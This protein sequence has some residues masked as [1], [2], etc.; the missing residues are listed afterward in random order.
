MNT[1]APTTD[2]GTSCAINSGNPSYF[3]SL[4]RKLLFCLTCL[5][6]SSSIQAQTSFSTEPPV[7]I[8]EFTKFINAAKK[9]ELTKTMEAF[10]LAWKSNK[11]VPEQQTFIIRIC[12]NMMY[13]QLPRDPYFELLLSNLDLYYKK[14]FSP[15]LLKQWQL[16]SKTLLDKSPKEY[17]AFLETANSLFQDNTFCNIES[18]RWYASNSNFEFGFTNN[19]VSIIYKNL[20]LIC[21]AGIDKIKIFNCSG[22][23]YPDKHLW[24]GTQGRINWARV[25]KPE[26]EVHCEFHRHKIDFATAGFSVD[27]ALLT[28]PKVSSTKI[29]GKLTEKV[30]HASDSGTIKKSGYPQFVSYEPTIEIKGI[31]GDQAIYKGGFTIKGNITNSQN[32]GEGYASITLLFK[33]K[34]TVEIK[35][36]AFRLDSGKV[37]S[38]HASVR[39]KADTG[40]ITHP[41]II[42]HYNITKKKMTLTKGSEGLMRMAFTDTY[43]GVE[44]D[45]DQV[46]WDQGQPNMDFDMLANDKTAYV[47]T[48]SFFKK[49][50]FEKQQGALNHNPL[51]TLFF[52]VKN[53]KDTSG[54]KKGIMRS[55]HINDYASYLGSAKEHLVQQMMNLADDGFI[56]YNKDNDSIYVRDKLYN[57]ISNNKGAKDYD[58][59]RFA[60]VIAAKPNLT[61]NF[62]SHE[63]KME[64]VRRF[65]FSDSQN[66]LAIPT[67]QLLIIKKDKN[68]HFSGMIRA[69]RIDFFSKDFNFN[70]AGFQIDNTTID[71]MV[72][73]YPDMNTNTLRKVESV[74]SNTYGR[75]LIDKSNNKSGLKDYPEYPIF[76]A[77]RGSEINYDRAAT[78]NHAYK[79]DKFKFEVDPF[80]IDSL[81]NFTI[82]GFGF[83]GTLVSDGIFPDIKNVAR[84]QPDYSLGFVDKVN[85]PMYGGKGQGDLTINLSNRGFYGSGNLIYETSVSKS[86]EYL[87]LP[88]ATVGT[89]TSFDLPESAKYP[90]VA[91]NNV[92]TEWYPKQDKMF[93]TKLD[94]NFRMFKTQYDFEGKLT[95]TPQ[96][97]RGDG[98][99]MWPEAIF[100]SNEMV[101]GRNKSKADVSSIR[102]YAVDPSKFAFESN[103]VKGDV[104]FDKREGKFLTNVVGSMTDFPFN[105][106]SSNMNDYKWDMNKKTM[107]VK[108]GAAM[109]GMK[110]FFVG[111]PEKVRDSVKFECA[112][113]KFDLVN[114]VL[115]MEKIPYIDI[116]DSRV[117]PFEGKA[118]VRE[119]AA[120]D[121]LDSSRIEA[122]RIDKFHEIKNCRTTILGGNTL[123]ATGYYRYIDKY[124]V[125]QPLFVDS[126][127][128]DKEKHLV[129]Y[130]KISD[131]KNF[132][133][134]K[135]I[136]FKGLF[137]II[138]TRRPIQF[139]GYVRPMHSFAM[140]TLWIRYKN[141]VD[142]QNVIIDV[143]DPR[144]KDN[145][146]LALGLYFA[147]DSNHVYPIMFDLKRRYNDPELQSDTG[148]LFYDNT[149][150]AFFAGNEDKLLHHANKGNFIQFNDKD[151]SVNAE[152]RFDFQVAAPKVNFMTAGT[153]VHS[154]DDSTYRFNLMMWLDFPFPSEIKST[155]QKILSTEGAGSATGSQKTAEN[156]MGIYELISD[157]KLAAKMVKSTEATGTIPADGEFKTGFVFTDVDF[158]FNRVR[159][160]FIATGSIAMPLFNGIVVNKRFSTTLAIEKKRSGDKIYL[161][162][163]TD[164]GDWMYFEYTRGSMLIATNNNE[165]ATAVALE[166]SKQTD[167]Q[168][169]IRVGTERSK[170][171]FLRK[172]D[173]DEDE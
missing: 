65:T 110:P 163:I 43:H 12:N 106:Y 81:D 91:G 150:D 62:L 170:D 154:A 139:I 10:A 96:D 19:K 50:L 160:K 56:Y 118:I 159:R 7:F 68:L 143:R 29:L 123:A 169:L 146:Y 108:P 11:I 26:S 41:N 60:S 79:A 167:E 25:G 42:F 95:L 151:H 27:S 45:V 166:A 74:L 111:L 40:F 35:S 77:E 58:V 1:T 87:L 142:P 173:I 116:A 21:D 105:S 136:G 155:I 125:E 14:K 34:P 47:E 69:G 36:S 22:V 54:G 32:F 48:N 33:G 117:Y 20:D 156:K 15:N 94:S 88:D 115:Y 4:M 168:F 31:V 113:A 131:D 85:L 98:R 86:P 51:D 78:H 16:I 148:I 18:R 13:K 122:N 130:G 134:D 83:G 109:A 141:I 161:Y 114:F 104:D 90:L 5:L 149:K 133:L 126:I 84:I 100:A 61:Y 140:E 72:I 66:V 44:I 2:F 107:E 49:F 67:E 165:L 103:N 37:M 6:L 17:L 102:I 3:S 158:A 38:Q 147:T 53:N 9:P 97:L 127:R 24:L 80:T 59:L 28:Y 63:L 8:E 55:F 52:Y 171:N 89:S 137:E 92:Q 23:Y 135:K 30:S 124:K 152:G 39:I 64:G 144:D 73:Y 162:I 172:N 70:Y 153:A 75:I 76:I 93:Q 119:R 99:L 129:G 128:I 121:R 46:T 138:S 145:K 82:A 157:E 164:M 101:F 132:R 57:W 71:S 120:M 112:Y